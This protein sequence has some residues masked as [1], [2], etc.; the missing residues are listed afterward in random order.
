MRSSTRRTVLW[1][2][3]LVTALV[4]VGLAF[5]R[6]EGGDADQEAEAPVPAGPRVPDD[7]DGG[8]GDAAATDTGDVAVDRRVARCAPGAPAPSPLPEPATLRV[9]VPDRTASAAPLFVAD[10]L[11]EF[12]AENLTVE[13]A[14]MSQADAYAAMAAGDLDVVVGGIDGPFFDAVHDGL[15]ARLVLGGPLAGAPGDLDSPQAGLWLRADLI[16][17]DGS[18]RD[19]EHRTVLVPGGLG[20]AALYPV[21]QVLGQHELNANQIDV[22]AAANSHAADRLLAADVGGAWLT[23]PAAAAVA[24]DDSLRLVA[25]RPGSEPIEGT[26]FSPALVA[27]RRAVGLAYVRAVVRTINTHLGDGYGDDALGALADALGVAEDEVAAGPDP[28]FDWEVRA[29]TTTRIQESL[30][31]VGG[32]RYEEIEPERR[33]VDRSL[34]DEVVGAG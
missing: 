23:E 18:W 15:G 4:L 26:V 31:L 25:T 12:A 32:V 13:I 11:D 28:L 22:E 8:C 14:E 19:V 33:L 16:S 9:A 5:V 34:V 6:G 30:I 7:L 21:E 2:L 24:G 17:G 27:E 20:G 10:A 3:A 1:A 29:G